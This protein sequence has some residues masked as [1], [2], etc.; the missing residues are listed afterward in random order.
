MPFLV[1][2]FFFKQRILLIYQKGFMSANVISTGFT[3]F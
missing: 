1:D 3:F 2:F